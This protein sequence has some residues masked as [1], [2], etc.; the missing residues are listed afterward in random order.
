MCEAGLGFRF[1][2]YFLASMSICY[3]D[4]LPSAPRPTYDVLHVKGIL[5]CIYDIFKSW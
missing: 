1:G 4:I 3:S 2:E 5:E